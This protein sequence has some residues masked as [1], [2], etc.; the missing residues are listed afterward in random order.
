[1]RI[2]LFAHFSISASS[3]DTNS[4][5]LSQFPMKSSIHLIVSMSMSLDGSSRRYTSGSFRII[6]AI[7]TFI[8][9]PPERVPIFLSESKISLS[10][11]TSEA[12]LDM[13]EG[14]ASR[15]LSFRDMYSLMESSLVSSSISWGRYAITR[16][17]LLHSPMTSR[18]SSTR[19]GSY[20]HFM[21]EDFP[22]PSS[23]I[24]TAL[25][26]SFRTKDAS[27]ISSLRSLL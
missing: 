3:C 26:P 5:I 19:P 24:I 2:I 27:F 25:S 8:L 1:M 6:D 21:S 18:Y 12:I 14:T 16:S 13:T 11:M 22:F 15:N 4:T 7:W 9:S 17:S 20:I 23:P 10:I